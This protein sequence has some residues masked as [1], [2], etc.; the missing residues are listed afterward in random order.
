MGVKRGPGGRIYCL[1][2]INFQ[3]T[4][5]LGGKKFDAIKKTISFEKFHSGEEEVA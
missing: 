3:R 1:G 5:C 4:M 2:N